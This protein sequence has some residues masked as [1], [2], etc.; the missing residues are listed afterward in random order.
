MYWCF[1]EPC[2]IHDAY[3]L[4]KISE[5]ESDISFSFINLTKLDPY[6]THQDSSVHCPSWTKMTNV[7][8]EHLLTQLLYV[9]NELITQCAIS[10]VPL[11]N[12]ESF[13][14]SLEKSHLEAK[15]AVQEMVMVMRIMFPSKTQKIG[16][17]T[18]WCNSGLIHQL[19]IRWTLLELC[20][21]Y[22]GNHCS[23]WLVTLWSTYIKALCTVCRPIQN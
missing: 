20:Y 1:N 14:R 23:M 17:K 6:I 13:V 3:S 22:V 21:N 9:S 19:S 8:D 10:L 5:I 18:Q 4:V 11:R 12:T 16:F 2:Q 15:P 7:K